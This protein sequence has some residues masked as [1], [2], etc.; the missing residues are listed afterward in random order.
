MARL[1]RFLDFRII[2]RRDQMVAYDCDDAGQFAEV[3]DATER[4]SLHE[5]NLLQSFAPDTL[6]EAKNRG[7]CPAET[8][9]AHL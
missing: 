4:L 2:G 3:S 8:A 7:F 6:I 9:K 1:R 5:Q